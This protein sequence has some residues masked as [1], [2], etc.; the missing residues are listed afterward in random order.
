MFVTAEVG[1]NEIISAVEEHIAVT[2]EDFA[3]IRCKSRLMEFQ[4]KQYKERLSYVEQQ[5]KFFE[6]N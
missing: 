5:I 2:E 4:T 6:E 1:V 3:L